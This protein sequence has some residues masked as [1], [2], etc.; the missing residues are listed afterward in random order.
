M[1]PMYEKLN[2]LMSNTMPDYN[3][4]IMRGPF[5]KLTI[6][7]WIDRQPGII[8]ELSYKVN[9][10]SSWEI[11]LDEPEGGMK[12]LILP[13]VI[14]VTLS[15]KPIGANTQGKNKTFAKGN[16]NS[17]IAQNNNGDINYITGSI[18]SG[19]FRDRETIAMGLDGK[20]DPDIPSIDNI[21][22]QRLQPVS[23]TGPEP[24]G[25][26]KKYLEDQQKESLSLANA[27]NEAA[28]IGNQI[29]A[30]NIGNPFTTHGFNLPLST[31]KPQKKKK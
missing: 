28:A 1:Q 3:D 30:Q 17:N 16:E 21:N 14:D 23:I 27:Q 29:A 13:H 6:G 25:V 18:M 24:S 31:K 4:N 15:F 5:T 7:N 26:F 9:E 11:A 20:L 8:T 22:Q 2:Y 10:N 12:L 19:E